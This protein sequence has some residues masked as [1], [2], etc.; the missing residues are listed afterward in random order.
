MVQPVENSMEVLKKLKTELQYDRAIPLLD[1]YL[2]KKIKNTN[3]KRYMHPNV[4]SSII[5][6]C[7]YM[8]TTKF[9]HLLKRDLPARGRHEDNR[10]LSM[11][12]NT[13]PPHS[14]LETKLRSMGE[15]VMG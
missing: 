9:C 6:N 11:S 3:S 1:I 4:H 5:Y 13:Q 10:I 12:G 15:L 8:E 7:Q 2:G 14:G